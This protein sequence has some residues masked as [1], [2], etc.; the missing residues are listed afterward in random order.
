VPKAVVDSK[1]AKVLKQ[2][3]AKTPKNFVAKKSLPPV[4]RKSTP[5]LTSGSAFLG[6]DGQ[7]NCFLCN[8]SKEGQ[9][10]SFKDLPRLKEHYAKCLYNESK[11]IQFVPPND[12]NSDAEGNPIDENSVLYR[13][14]IKGCWL[15]KKGGEKGK[16]SYKVLAHHMASQHGVLEKILEADPRP[17]MQD[18]MKGLREIEQSRSG[19]VGCR[20]QKCSKLQFKAD[21]KREIKLHYA[22]THFSDWFAVNPDTG[23]PDNF[24]KSGNRA[25][26]QTCTGSS[27]KPVYIQGEKEAIRGHLVVKHDMLA[28]VLIQAGETVKEAR[29]VISDLY[30]DRLTDVYMDTLD[31]H[32]LPLNEDFM[33]KISL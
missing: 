6:E 20:F 21:N 32:T 13:C 24:T 27:D 2:P 28:E 33:S 11:Y 8:G 18:I 30:P 10:L 23:V 19:V 29:E 5:P 12:H 1:A 7:H 3:V 9:G 14:E 26:C 16:V 15:Q 4:A 25:V 17:F 22:G 31:K